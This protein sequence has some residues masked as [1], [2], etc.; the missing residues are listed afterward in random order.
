L[1][2]GTFSLLCATDAISSEVE[3]VVIGVNSVVNS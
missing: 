1:P 3:P 2:D